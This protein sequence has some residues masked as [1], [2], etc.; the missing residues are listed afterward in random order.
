MKSFR[1]SI[2]AFALIALAAA[3]SAVAI[4]FGYVAAGARAVYRV[5][6]D[7]VS[8]GLK[9]A[10]RIDGAGFARPAVLLTQARAFVLRLAKRE[11]PH[12]TP[13]WR[14]CPSI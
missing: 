7:L 1:S 5:A 6:C 10:A 12:L 11:R 9:L 8:G 4:G 13:G 14:M 3:S 2:A